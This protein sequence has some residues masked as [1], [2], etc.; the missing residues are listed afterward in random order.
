MMDFIWHC[1]RIINIYKLPLKQENDLI[2]SVK[3]VNSSK[4]RNDTFPVVQHKTAGDFF[5]SQ[6]LF[7]IFDVFDRSHLTIQ[8]RRFITSKPEPQFDLP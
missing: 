7:E 4:Y 1:E 6:V 2:R 5:M 3:S 8:F